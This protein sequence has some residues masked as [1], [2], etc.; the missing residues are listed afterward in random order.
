M[1]R[2]TLGVCGMTLAF[3]SGAAAASD[4]AMTLYGIADATIQYLGNGSAHSF[5]ERSGGASTSIFG[6]RGS[7]D[8]GGGLH[9]KFVLEN[10]FNVNNGSLFVDSGAMFVRQSWIGVQDD[11]YGSLTFGRQYDPG[12]FLIYPTDPFGLNDATSPFSAAMGAIDRAT[13]ATQFDAGRDDNS[14]QYQSPL[15]GGWRLRAMFAFASTV[16]APLPKNGG[17]ALGV[18]LSYTGHGAYAGI[19]YGNQ[20]SGQLAFPGLPA[21]LDLPAAQFFGAALA[22]RWGSVNLQFNYT[23]N[24]PND[25]APGTLTARLGAAHAYSVAEAG[26]TIMATP[27]DAIELAVIE[28]S[29]RGA[30][31]NALGVQLGVDHFL[32]KRTSVYAR[33][34]W[35]GNHGDS[36]V[37]WSG[38]TVS[39]RGATQVLA[40]IG[41]AHRF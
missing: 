33:A 30:H 31:D 38:V 1:R 26:A 34:G 17:N 41:I 25:A 11:R 21:R 32:S 29:V 14:I 19:G 40:G 13:L 12:F 28:R 4:A 20:R 36:T 6:L 39:A 24:R 10:G 8:L 3:A 35:I 27:V 18:A 37:G 23:Y 2:F 9:V 16:T 7:E 15:V 5:S 22:Y